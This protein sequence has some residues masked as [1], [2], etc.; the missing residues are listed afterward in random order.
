MKKYILKLVLCLALLCPFAVAKG[1]VSLVFAEAPTITVAAGGTFTLTLNLVVSAGEPV[2]GADY[3]LQELSNAGFTIVSRDITGSVFPDVFF[4][5]TA[6]ASSADNAA[7]VGP[8]NAL[9]TRNDFDLGGDTQFADQTTGSG[10]VATYT[11]LAPNVT[12]GSQYTISTTSNPGTGWVSPSNTSP[13]DHAFDSHAS[14]LIT[15]VPEPTTWSLLG[16][17]ALGAFGLNLL[18]ARRR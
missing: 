2:V 7:P 10:F 18:R 3:Y 12:P 14:I 5:N 15:V 11:I 17:G 6:V 16:L 9:N 1:A 8:D 13:T 4:S